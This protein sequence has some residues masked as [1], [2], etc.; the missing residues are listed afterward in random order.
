MLGPD[1]RPPELNVLTGA[2][3]DAFPG[4]L[5][6]GAVECGYTGLTILYPETDAPSELEP[7]HSNSSA[8]SD[9]LLT[10]PPYPGTA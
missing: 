8:S 9:N 2:E 1:Q 6:D 10:D 5:P 7:D 3:A 4:G